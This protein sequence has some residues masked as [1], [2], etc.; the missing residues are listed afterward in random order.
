MLEQSLYYITI[1]GK[2]LKTTPMRWQNLICRT[3]QRTHNKK[4]QTIIFIL[5][6]LL[7]I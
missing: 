2:K 4:P 5:E 3:K 6:F 7:S 1:F